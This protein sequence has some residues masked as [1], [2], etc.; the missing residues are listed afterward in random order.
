MF[1]KKFWLV[2]L[3]SSVHFSSVFFS[4]IFLSS[5]S[6]LNVS[7]FFKSSLSRMPCLVGF[8]DLG[9]IGLDDP[10][11]QCGPGSYRTRDAQR[12]NKSRLI[13]HNPV[14]IMCETEFVVSNTVTF[15][16]GLLASWFL[17]NC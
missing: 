14:W 3:I 10:R 2:D 8:Q 17:G 5:V 13:T 6:S 11:P 16:I 9:V 4:V 15:I 1:K 7:R 12:T